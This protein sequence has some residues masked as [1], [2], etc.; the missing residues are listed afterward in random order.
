METVKG[1]INVTLGSLSME[2]LSVKIS[3]LA[4]P[5]DPDISGFT[6]TYGSISGNNGYAIDVQGQKFSSNGTSYDLRGLETGVYQ[7]RVCAKGN[8]TNVLASNYSAPIE[9]NRLAAPTDVRVETS[10]ASEGILTYNTVLNATGYYV[11]FDNN[12]QAVPVDTVKNMNQYVTEQ[13]TTVVYMVSTANYFNNDKTGGYYMESQPSKTANF[14]KLSAPTFGDTAFTNTQLIW[15]HSANMNTAVYTPTYD[16]YVANGT[17]YSGEKN[18]AT[19]DIS[20]LEVYFLR[21]GARQRHQLHQFGEIDARK[22]LQACRA[23]GD[24]R[25]RSVCLVCRGGHF[26]LCGLCGRQTDGYLSA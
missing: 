23:G 14:I 4:A 15:K 7:V 9:V 8:G 16:I 17:K 24:A 11:V 12:G 25:K 21:E 18:G 26:E 5:A 22:N 13:G 20:Y 19:I 10:D 3:V 1:K 2:S 6:Y